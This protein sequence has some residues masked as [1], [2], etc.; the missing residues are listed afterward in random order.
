M[1]RHEQK[2]HHVVIVGMGFAGLYAY[3]TLV[4]K[5]R[6]SDCLEVTII[7]SFDSFTFIPMIH[8]V[9]TGLLRPD[10][11]VYPLR[12]SVGPLVR[13]F[14]EGYATAVDL[15]NKKVTI[16]LTEG[17]AKDYAYDT[18][19]M[20]IGSVTNFFGTK[21]A[22]EFA[23]QLK[24]LDDARLLKNKMLAEFDDAADHLRA[25]RRASVDVVVVGGG[26]TGVELTG[27]LS[28][29]ME[30]LSGTFN[31]VKVPH[32]ITLLDGGPALVKGAHPW[33]SEKAHKILMS[34]PNVEVLLNMHVGEVTEEG[35]K[36]A[37]AMIPSTLTVWTAGVKAAELEWSPSGSVVPDE[38]TRRIPV[39]NILRLPEHGDVYVLGDQAFAC[40]VT[41][42]YPMR[43]QIAVRQGKATARNI[44]RTVRGEELEP[45]EWDD[46]GFI[47]S[48]GEGGAVAEVLGIHFSGPFAWAVYR[49]AYL[50]ALVGLRAKL[51]TA[52]EWTINLFKTRDMGK[53]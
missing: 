39:D 53:I 51:R 32:S 9:A 12:G 50:L 15:E 16:Q 20:G 10:S 21:G 46:R 37:D 3:Q 29:F 49:I 48:L 25:G 34:R 45:F 36:T 41:C 14:L 35:V 18:L 5:A 44:I 13:E 38:K 24:S 31:D 30:L 19:I 4:K 17:I 7:S 1:S 43:A 2:K 6:P 42:P 28:D 27:E 26:A 23:F 47:L 40:D 22:E 52:L 11:V 33:I 8:E